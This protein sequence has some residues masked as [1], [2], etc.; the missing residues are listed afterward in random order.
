M[1]P[2]GAGNAKRRRMPL[3]GRNHPAR[4]AKKEGRWWR[5][6]I[7][8]VKGEMGRRIIQTVGKSAHR[9]ADL[10]AAQILDQGEQVQRI[11]G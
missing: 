2:E 10:Q 6:E 1:H 3:Q 11:G 9:C 8:A 5:G 7:G 4:T